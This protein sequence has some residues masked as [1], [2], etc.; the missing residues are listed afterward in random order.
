M[1]NYVVC[2]ELYESIIMRNYISN[3]TFYTYKTSNPV[4]NRILFFICS[5]IN[6]NKSIYFIE[7]NTQRFS[8]Q[9]FV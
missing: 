6:S 9:V 4:V 1:K 7:S 5:V 3:T 8:N 2:K